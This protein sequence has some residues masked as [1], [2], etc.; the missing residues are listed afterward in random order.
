MRERFISV[1]ILSIFCIILSACQ[2]E[3]EVLNHLVIKNSS[4]EFGSLQNPNDKEL[5]FRV[6]INDYGLEP[7]LE[8]NVRFI[9]QNTDIRD[10]TGMNEIE[11]LE[12]YKTQTFPNDGVRGIVTGSSVEISKEF[13]IDEKKKL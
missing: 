7:E 13:S 3:R 2:K 12:T 8:Y 5:H 4:V 10:W 9:I 11:V 6:Q 1:I